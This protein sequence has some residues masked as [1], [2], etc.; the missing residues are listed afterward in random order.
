[1]KPASQPPALNGRGLSGTRS[2]SNSSRSASTPVTPVSLR[3]VLHPPIGN[4]PTRQELGAL[5]AAVDLDAGQ[6][7]AAVAAAGSEPSR[8]HQVSHQVGGGGLPRHVKYRAA[9]EAERVAQLPRVPPTPGGRPTLAR[10]ARPPVAVEVTR[11]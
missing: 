6:A 8:P 9:A 1:M 4:R 3:W 7:S 2:I 10:G 5:A 11:G